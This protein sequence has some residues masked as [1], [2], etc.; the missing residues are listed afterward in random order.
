M[1]KDV[2]SVVIPAFNEQENIKRI[3]TELLPVLGKMNVK[4]EVLVVDDGSKDD[5][6][7]ETRKIIQKHRNVRLVSHTKNMGLA[8][9]TRTG[10]KN[11]NGNI[12]VFLDSDFTFHPREI[13][14]LYAKYKSNNC[15]CVV[16]S[17][18]SPQGST[19]MIFY[20]MILSKGVNIMYSTLLGKKISTISSISRLYRTSELKKLKLESKGFDICAEIL[21][22]MLRNKNH[23]E[24]VPVKLTTRIYGESKLDNKKEFINHMKLLSKLALW[25]IRD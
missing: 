21:V 19:D 12:I 6:A 1:A 13:P 9:A 7:K 24:E 8:E 11:A 10:I 4:Y 3:P 20:R 15:D 5:T 22:K 18:F 25:R 23:I 2:M 16:G 14:K 17:H